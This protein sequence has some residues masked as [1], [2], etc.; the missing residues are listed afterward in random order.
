LAA[1]Y[2]FDFRIPMG[3]PNGN[4]GLYCVQGGISGS[5]PSIFANVPVAAV[6]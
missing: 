6:Q 4:F 1:V 3:T 5:G 2:Q